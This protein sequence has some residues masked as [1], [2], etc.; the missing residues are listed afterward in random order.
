M[1]PTAAH[2]FLIPVSSAAAARAPDAFLLGR[3]LD[4]TPQGPPADRRPQWQR[5]HARW[6]G[7]SKAELAADPTIAAYADFQ[8]RIGVDPRTTPPAAQNLI[9]RFLLRPTLERHP[10]IHPIVDA[11]NLA[12]AQTRVPIAVFDAAHLAPPLT[13]DALTEDEL[14]VPIGA[15]APVTVPAGALVLRDTRGLLSW[16]CYRDG[17]RQRVR[18]ETA[19]VLVLACGVAGVDHATVRGAIDAVAGALAVDHAV[20]T[21]PV[22]SVTPA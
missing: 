20:Q 10:V 11:G 2:D 6:A 16:F 19:S 1:E 3:V 4:V 5:L 18:A 14:L 13:L 17:N 8:R 7:R 15:D 12:A 9:Q 21:I 22:D